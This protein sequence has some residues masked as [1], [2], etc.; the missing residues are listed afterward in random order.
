MLRNELGVQD[1]D[2]IRGGKRQKQDRLS[3][4]KQDCDCNL[5]L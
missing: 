3:K 5:L 4:M 1:D 2:G